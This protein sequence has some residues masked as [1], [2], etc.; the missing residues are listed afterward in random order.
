[1][2]V[3]TDKSTMLAQ[4]NR[5]WWRLQKALA[6]L[7]QIEMTGIHIE[8][9]WTVKDIIAH[10]TFWERNLLDWLRQAEQGQSPN[11]PAAGFTDEIID[12]M[13]EENYHKHAQRFI[14]DV[15]ADAAEVH[16]ALMDALLRLPEDPDDARY[17][18]W[19][20]GKPPWALIAGNTYAHYEEHLQSIEAYLNRTGRSAEKQS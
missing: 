7:A 16:E 5:A 3:A 10:I 18:V 14:H 9:N 11:L 20:N 1:M 8:N 13:N 4:T 19:H 17:K 15:L 12:R 6:G 2:D